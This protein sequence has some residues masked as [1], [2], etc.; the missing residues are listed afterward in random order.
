M[1]C[2]QTYYVQ[3][4]QCDVFFLTPNC[5]AD[6]CPKCAHERLTVKRAKEIQRKA[7][8]GLRKLDEA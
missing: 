4:K 3:C 1:N 7:E 2:I 5:L 8:D 6:L